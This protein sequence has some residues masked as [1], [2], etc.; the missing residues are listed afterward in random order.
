MIN[1]PNGKKY[2]KRSEDAALQSAG[3]AKSKY[4]AERIEVDG[5]RFDSKKEA[6]RYRQLRIMERA[7]IIKELQLQVP[8]VLI[9]KNANGREVKY[10][11][12]FV[13]CQDDKQ[14]VEDVKGFKT[15]VYRLKKRMMKEVYGIDIREV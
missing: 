12:D 8:F 13:Y 7:G 11:A 1:Y 4:N 9:P 10:I 3:T 14:I 15:D 2:R 5:I 6:N